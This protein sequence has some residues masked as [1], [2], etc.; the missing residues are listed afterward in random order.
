MYRC[1]PA[2]LIWAFCTCCALAEE[3]RRLPKFTAAQIETLIAE[4][5][6]ERGIPGM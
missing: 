6:S 3:I 2:V 5:M 4:E 1:T